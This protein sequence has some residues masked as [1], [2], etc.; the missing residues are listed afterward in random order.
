[1]T[2]TIP[3]GSLYLPSLAVVFPGLTHSIGGVFDDVEFGSLT[4]VGKTGTPDVSIPLPLLH[5]SLRRALTDYALNRLSSP[6]G[7]H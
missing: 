7:L 6:K 3:H 2:I 5:L 1:M 4:I